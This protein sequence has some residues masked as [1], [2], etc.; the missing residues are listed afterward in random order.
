MP[1][2]NKNYLE[3]E[4][5]EKQKK[6]MLKSLKKGGMSAVLGFNYDGKNGDE[7]RS[8]NLEQLGTKWDIDPRELKEV[9]I[10]GKKVLSFDTAWSPPVEFVY[11]ASKK[12]PGLKLRLLA[13]E[14]GFEYLGELKVKNG[15]TLKSYDCDLSNIRDS[16]CKRI[17]N[18][19]HKRV[20]ADKN[21]TWLNNVLNDY[22]KLNTQKMNEDNKKGGL[23]NLAF[24]R[25]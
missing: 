7:I 25:K 15:K 10:K 20:K 5:D 12:Y 4:G 19:V 2:W 17:F 6:K 18:E 22:K 21:E 14:P 23:L 16:K 11:N 1:N 8:L 13:V 24:W 3:I 9:K